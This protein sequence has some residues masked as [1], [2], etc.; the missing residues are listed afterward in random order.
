[1][2]TDQLHQGLGYDWGYYLEHIFPDRIHQGMLLFS[3]AFMGSVPDHPLWRMSIAGLPGLVREET[4]YAI[5][6]SMIT[7]MVLHF[8]GEG[9]RIMAQDRGFEVAGIPQLEVVRIL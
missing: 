6:P 7:A 5:G 4:F 9:L 1:M 3:N 2:T 8:G